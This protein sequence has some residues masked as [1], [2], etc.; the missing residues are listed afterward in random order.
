MEGEHFGENTFLLEK[1]LKRALLG[2]K[3]EEDQRENTFRVDDT[4]GS[5]GKYR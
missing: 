4:F 1:T 5:K 2:E 3:R